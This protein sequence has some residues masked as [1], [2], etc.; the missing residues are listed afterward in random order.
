M[1]AVWATLDSLSR[2]LREASCR[3]KFPPVGRGLLFFVATTRIFGRFHEPKKPER[4]LFGINRRTQDRG[5]KE[6]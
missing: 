6:A 4:Y 2:R 1:C 3:A 5:L